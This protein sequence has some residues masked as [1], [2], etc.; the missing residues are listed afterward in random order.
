MQD[1]R[2]APAGAE[3]IGG[4][5]D[6]DRPRDVCR[7][8]AS[9]TSR[10]ALLGG[11]AALAVANRRP[12]AAAAGSVIVVGAGVSG[13]K[14][15]RDL[16]DAGWSVTVL[17][18][19]DRIGGRI[20]TDESA[21]GVPIDLGASWIHGLGDENPIA[22]IA[23]AEGWRLAPT[24]YDDWTLYDATGREVPPEEEADG[25]RLYR[26]VLRSARKRAN[27]RNRDTSLRAALD[28]EMRRRRLSPEARRAVD[29]NVNVEIEHEYAGPARDL[30]V[31]WWDNDEWLGGRSDAMVRDGYRQLL[32]LLLGN[33]ADRLDVETGAAVE[34]VEHGPTGVRVT[35]AGEGPPRAADACVVTVPLGVLKA[36][37]IAFSP[38][39]PRAKRRA[40]AGLNMGILDKCFLRYPAR[41][42]D[43]SELVG[44]MAAT[45][46][47]WAEWY[48]L[49][50]VSGAPI[51]L[52]FNAADFAADLEDLPDDEIAAQA[53]SVLR[54]IYGS[55]IPEPTAFLVTKWG[56]DPWTRGSYAHVPP[57][58]NTTAYAEIGKPVGARLFFAGEHTIKNYPNTVA[59]AYMS[60]ARA[61]REVTKA[62]GGRR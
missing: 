23:R 11:A 61:A 19:R 1:G 2:T 39:L 8:A 34:R 53:H 24:D 6:A 26:D 14:A 57:G 33:G 31:W 38:P 56:K 5:A 30:S 44:H 48:D 13:L 40:I 41:F 3:T 36:N 59:G 45:A 7:R 17:E 52:G 12:A 50:R 42:W 62:V 18:A 43:D 4:L 22:R 46:G 28:R 55:S 54:A 10:R 51:I 16:H 27:R 37:A 25:Y 47:A 21:L 9:A 15:A 60:G 20:H 35:V 58:M 29:F 32:D 49:E